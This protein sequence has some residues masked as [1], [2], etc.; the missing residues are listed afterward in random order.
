[1]R[2]IGRGCGCRPVGLGC[3]LVAAKHVVGVEEVDHAQAFEARERVLPR[4]RREDAELAIAAREPQQEFGAA[5]LA[6]HVR[7]ELALDLF[8]LHVQGRG[9]GLG[10]RRQVLEDEVPLGNAEP[11]REWRRS[12]GSRS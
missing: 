5:V 3:G 1:M 6:F 7:G 2:P 11:R 8:E 4:V 12:R 10:Q 9:F